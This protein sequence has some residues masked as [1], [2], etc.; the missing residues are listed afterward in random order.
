ME[1]IQA[2]DIQ[3]P[4]RTQEPHEN[5]CQDYR[6]PPKEEQRRVLGEQ[7]SHHSAEAPGSCNDEHTG[8]ASSRLRPSRSSLGPRDPR[9]QDLSLPKQRPDRA[10]GSRPRQAATGSEPAHTKAP[11]L[12]HVGPQVHQQLETP[13]TGRSRSFPPGMETGRLPQQLNLGRAS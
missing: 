11:S 13:T 6:N 3:R 1:E 4:P 8:P 9:P 2:I 12:G 7:P 5:H 10:Q